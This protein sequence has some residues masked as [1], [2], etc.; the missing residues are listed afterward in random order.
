MRKYLII[1]EKSPRNYAAY[2]PDL[3]GCVATGK[4]RKAV[5]RNMKEAIEFHLEG[6][7]RLPPPPIPTATGY[8][9]VK[10]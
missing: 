4:T 10:A 2:C 6:F 1:Y 9:T 3:P 7:R 8:L 5:E